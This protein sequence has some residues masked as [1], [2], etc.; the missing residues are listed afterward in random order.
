MSS[1][2]NFTRIATL[3]SHA[4]P[5]SGDMNFPREELLERGMYDKIMTGASRA[6]SKP[7]NSRHTLLIPIPL[8]VD[9]FE[10]DLVRA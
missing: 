6:N 3:P 7:V 10:N 5:I 2:T 9:G 1:L 8:P 4:E